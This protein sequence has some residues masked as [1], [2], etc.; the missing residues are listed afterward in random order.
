MPEVDNPELALLAKKVDTL[1]I[2]FNQLWVQMTSS[3]GP[4][5]GGPTPIQA[6]PPYPEPYN[7]PGTGEQTL[8][9]NNGYR[10]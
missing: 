6:L 3:G 2:W 4:M 7:V 1:A 9:N 5:A 8:P 10:I